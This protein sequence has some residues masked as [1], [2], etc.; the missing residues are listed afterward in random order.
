MN[1]GDFFKNFSRHSDLLVAFGVVG[2]LIVM[3]LPLPAFLLDLLLATNITVSVVILM[4]TMYMIRPLEFS[5]FPGLLL[6]VTLFRLSLN[7]ATTRLILGEAYAGEVVKSFGTFVVSGNYVVGFVV[8]VIL[9]VIQFVVITKGATRIAEVA[10]R[11]TLDAMPGKQMAIDADLNAGLINEQQARNRRDEI[12]READFYGAMDGASKFVRGDAIAGIIITL[13]NIVGGFII[14][15]VQLNLNFMDALQTYTLMTVGDGL[16][17]QI[18]ALMISTASGIIVTRAASESNLGQDIVRQLTLQPRAILIAAS[19]LL[20]FAIVPGMPTIPFLSLSLLVGSIGYFSIRA[21]QDKKA[22]QAAAIE[23]A[24]SKEPEKIEDMLKIDPMEIEIGYSLI[25]LVDTSQGGDL[26]ERIALIRKQLAGELGIIVPPIRIR[27][28]IQLDADS[29]RIKIRGIETSRG[30][31]MID[32]LLAMAPG[33]VEEEIAGTPTREPAFGLPAIWIDKKQQE[34][35]ELM[36]YTVVEPSAV[37]ATH[38]SEVIKSHAPNL[39]NRQQTKELLDNIKK[40]NSTLVDEVIPNLLSVGNV[41]K[42]LHNLL[43]E[44]IPVRDLETILEAL[45]DYAVLTKDMD[46]LTEY[47]RAALKRTISNLYR[48][49]SN[50]LYVLTIDPKLEKLM[51]DS[52][53]NPN[54]NGR[55]ILPPAVFNRFQQDISAKIKQVLD[56]GHQPIVLASPGIRLY[57]RRMIEEFF[58]Q[59][60]VLSYNEIE[61]G[62]NIL[63]LGMLGGGL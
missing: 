27:D 35:A 46:L 12:S 50:E 29:Y 38:L 62:I 61:T 47:V 58:P 1:M 53:K 28:N 23:E 43:R 44:Q 2:I 9:V 59:V 25:P 6:V 32:H 45:A 26:L 30:S 15:M 4:V 24:P 48:N 5:V 13:I 49:E 14:G 55:I 42:V 40:D 56:S 11:F 19:L 18:P 60:I 41:Q 17:S 63:S 33:Q 16:V 7:V 51:T 36:G 57:F 31:L 10:A 20:V 22:A 3:I 37:L 52:I 34:Y 8:F 21:A 39:L 54:F